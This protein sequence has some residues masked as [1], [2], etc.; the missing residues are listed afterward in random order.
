MYGLASVGKKYVS[1]RGKWH[2]IPTHI[3]IRFLL[4]LLFS[5]SLKTIDSSSSTIDSWKSI[6]SWYVP[7]FILRRKMNSFIMKQ[8]LRHPSIMAYIRCKLKL[9]FS[10]GV[11]CSYFSRTKVKKNPTENSVGLKLFYGLII[12]L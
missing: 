6:P 8:P 10:T 4:V 11:I 12:K 7:P 3:S 2:I 1:I 9:F 5:I